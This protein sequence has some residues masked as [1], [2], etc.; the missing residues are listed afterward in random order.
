MSEDVPNGLKRHAGLEQARC[1]RVSEQMWAA[2]AVQPDTDLRHVTAKERVDA[3]VSDERSPRRVHPNEHLSVLARG[4][5]E[6]QIVE[7]GLAYAGQ[8]WQ[9][10]S[11]AGL[12]VPDPQ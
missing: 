7:Q 8:K 9:T 10:G 6:T 1:P 5:R 12:Y 3:V 4:A 2:L 11:G